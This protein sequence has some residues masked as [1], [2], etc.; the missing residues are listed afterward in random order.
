MLGVSG[1]EVPLGIVARLGEFGNHLVALGFVPVMGGGSVIV[2]NYVWIIW[3]A[4]IALTL[5]NV[6]QIFHNHEPGLY[7]NADAFRSLRKGWLLSWDYN[8][9]WAVAVALASVAGILT[10]Q[11]I[12]EFLYFQF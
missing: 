2:T 7:E 12:S 9:R 11:Q 8:N 3:S 5:P 10:L 1:F 6:A 4:V